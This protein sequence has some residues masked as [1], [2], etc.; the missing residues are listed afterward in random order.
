M[1]KLFYS[2]F[3]LALFLSVPSFA[4]TAN[5]PSTAEENTARKSGTIVEVSAD[6]RS[7]L[8]NVEGTIH[9]FENL[10]PT[11]ILVPGDLVIVILPST[12]HYT[13]APIRP[14]QVDRD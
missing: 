13:T 2:L 4:Q 10:K 5:S 7:G 8:V 9:P 3:V 11:L 14:V 6:G 12:A 1:K